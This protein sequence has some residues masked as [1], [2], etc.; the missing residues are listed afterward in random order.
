MTEIA[1]PILVTILVWWFSTGAILYVEGL[2]RRTHPW[3]LAAAGCLALGAL[4]VI[5]LTAGEASVANAYL[6]FMATLVVWGWIE[7]AFLTGT[8]VGPRR[9]PCPPDAAGWRRF[10]LASAA[11][12]DHEI[13]IAL[14][15]LAIVVLVWGAPNPVALW[16]FAVLWV[17]RISA[18]LNIFLGAPNIAD[19]FLPAHLGYLSSYFRR[20]PLNPLMPVSVTAATVVLALMG[21]AVADPLAGPFQRVALMLAAS[22]LAL[23]ILEHW[24]MFLPLPPTLL[25]A[26]GLASRR[27]TG[28]SAAGAD[29]SRLHSW[30][31][32]MVEPVD[33]GALRGVLDQVAVG[34]F[35]QVI[36]MS[37]LGRSA[38]GWIRFGVEGGRTELRPA[39][40]GRFQPAFVTAVG[41]DFDAAR[42]GKALAACAA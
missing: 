18:K 39:S 29:R 19:A 1:I 4:A 11:I 13:A 3:S 27:R 15:G 38:E 24:L 35:G 14:A 26:W 37:G 2:P 33:A 36:S 21:V 16:I 30:E 41:R 9:E 10:R 6:A 42:L 8:I 5:G 23:A 17:M 7:L 40:S 20:R 34:Q 12:M 25:W 28:A 32:A 31:A 22:L